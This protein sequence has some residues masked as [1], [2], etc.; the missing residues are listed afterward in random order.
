MFGILDIELVGSGPF[1]VLILLCDAHFQGIPV[2]LPPA[3]AHLE[4]PAGEEGGAG[5]EPD[6]EEGL[7]AASQKVISPFLLLPPG[8]IG[9]LHI[10]FSLHV[11]RHRFCQPSVVPDVSLGAPRYQRPAGGPLL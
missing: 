5:E 10:G 6:E 3:L 8:H 9:H 11:R 2:P 4:E 1:P 7:L